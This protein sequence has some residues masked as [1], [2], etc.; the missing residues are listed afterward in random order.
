MRAILQNW[1]YWISL[2]KLIKG[3]DLKNLI[4]ANLPNSITAIGIILTVWLD[5]LLF[6]SKPAE[7][8]LLI[9]LLTISI[10]FSDLIDGWLARRWQIVSFI[11]GLLDKF[12]DKFFACSVFVYFLKELWRWTDG[13]W[14]AF[15]KGLIILV[16][17]NEFF[18]M[19]I[20][21]VGFIRGLDTDTHWTGKVK[22]D[23]YFTAIGWWFF[24]G[25]LMSSLKGDFQNY[26]YKGLIPLLFIGSFFGI[27]SVV[28]YLQRF[29]SS[30][31]K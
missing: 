29:N 12:R 16:V 20:W 9:L 21:I 28:A 15:V 6:W 3:V 25:W 2:T 31:N 30:E 1:D 18:L 24:L 26:L 22:T 27:L 23:F 14:L 10:L 5:S 8:R 17:I 4:R 7:H 11:G 19:Y 13:I